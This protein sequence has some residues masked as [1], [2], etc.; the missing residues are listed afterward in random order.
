M[1][2]Q[3]PRARGRR[4]RGREVPASSSIVL[5]AAALGTAQV[6]PTAVDIPISPS[7]PV[8]Q[9]GEETLLALPGWCPACSWTASHGGNEAG[10]RAE[11]AKLL[12]A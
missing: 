9:Q 8:G 10:R 6:D 12:R 4:A 5:R 7:S 2:I 3:L 11:G 1:D